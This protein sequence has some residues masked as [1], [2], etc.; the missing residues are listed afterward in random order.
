M[1]HDENGLAYKDLPV[2]LSDAEKI[3]ARLKEVLFGTQGTLGLQ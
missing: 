2:F 3:K 1:Q